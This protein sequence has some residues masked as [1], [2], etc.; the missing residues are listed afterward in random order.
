MKEMARNNKIDAKIVDDIDKCF[1][2][3]EEIWK[4]Y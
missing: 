4:R 1:N 2:K 3:G